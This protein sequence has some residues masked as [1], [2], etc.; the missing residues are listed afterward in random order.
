MAA[1]KA[2]LGRLMNTNRL[3]AGD[4]KFEQAMSELR[5]GRCVR[6]P[7]MRTGKIKPVIVNGGLARLEIVVGSVANYWLPTDI[8]LCASDWTPAENS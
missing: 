1:A 7:V 5:A 3:K 8:E 2:P 6:R 4:M